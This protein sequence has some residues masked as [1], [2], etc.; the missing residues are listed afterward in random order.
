MVAGVCSGVGRRFGIDPV[1][2]RVAVVVLCFV[3]GSGAILYLAGWLF[4]PADDGPAPVADWFGLGASEPQVREAGLVVGAVLA[5]LAALGDASLWNA[6]WLGWTAA[7]IVVPV[8]FVLWVLS[9]RDTE[10]HTP[11]DPTVSTAGPDPDPDSTGTDGAGTTRTDLAA[12]GT[13]T[14]ATVP[15]ADAPVAGPAAAPTPARPARPREPFSW[16]PTVLTL[17][18]IAIVTAVTWLVA[19]PERAVLVAIALAVTGL[20]LLLSA[21][22]RGGGPLVL[23]GLVLLP[24]LAVSTWVPT[25][26]AGD[27]RV[28]VTSIDGLADEYTLGAGRFELDLTA[29]DA[30]ELEG[31]TV[32]VDTGLGETVVRLPDDV[33]VDVEASV[34]A[35]ELDVLGERTDGLNRTLTADDPGRT[36]RLVVDHSMGRVE[37]T[38]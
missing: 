38:R 1:V 19:A 12:T 13:A 2:L 7:W 25:W 35:G 23:L 36:L 30:D 3:G 27:D 16:A 24:V 29:L 20:G 6:G 11:A 8:A 14:T 18:T 21:L 34:W 31:R 10:R 28:E 15:T 32:R 33:A 22:T 9:R 4:L 37:V 26:S 5:A 17:S